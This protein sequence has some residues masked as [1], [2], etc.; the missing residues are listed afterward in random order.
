MR[1]IERKLDSKACAVVWFS[2]WRY[3]KEEHLIVPLL[4]SVREGEGLVKWSDARRPSKA[5]RMAKEVAATVGKAAESLLAGFTIKAGIPGGPELSYDIN[6]SI[7]RADKNDADD[8]AARVPRSFYHASFNAMSDAF[9][10]FL[11]GN[12]ERRISCIC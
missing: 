3:E 11:G 7:T 1:A 9:G 10:K 4:D 6:K 8:I 12:K 2:A 5:R